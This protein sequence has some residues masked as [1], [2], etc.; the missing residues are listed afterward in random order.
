MDFQNQSTGKITAT[1]ELNYCID[2]VFPETIFRTKIDRTGIVF[3]HEIKT[4]ECFRQEVI[5]G[6]SKTKVDANGRSVEGIVFATIVN[7]RRVQA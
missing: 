2:V 5:V 3:C 1:V 4:I 7:I 6:K